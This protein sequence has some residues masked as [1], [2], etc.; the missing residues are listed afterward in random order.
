MT[1]MYENTSYMQII[2]KLFAPFE[3]AGS[4]NTENTIHNVSRP[5]EHGSQMSTTTGHRPLN[6]SPLRRRTSSQPRRTHTSKF[7]RRN[8][9]QTRRNQKVAVSLPVSTQPQRNPHATIR[10]WNSTQTQRIHPST[11]RTIATTNVDQIFSFS[12]Q[13]ELNPRLKFNLQRSMLAAEAQSSALNP[14]CSQ[15]SYSPAYIWLA[16]ECSRASGP[17]HKPACCDSPTGTF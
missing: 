15:H 11:L 4:T 12:R 7:R 8:S 14:Q 3:H 1:R 17:W 2:H 10:H 16:T 6:S 13:R 9:T 5:T